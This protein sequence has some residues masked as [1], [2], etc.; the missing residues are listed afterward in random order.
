MGKYNDL[1]AHVRLLE[2]WAKSAS[3][4]EGPPTAVPV[5]ATACHDAV[6]QQ[7]ALPANI[8]R[9]VLRSA[10]AANVFGRV[11]LDE[12]LPALALT[13]SRPPTAPPP[14]PPGRPPTTAPLPGWLPD[15]LVEW[16]D[17]AADDSDP[18]DEVFPGPADAE[19]GDG[20]IGEFLSG[21][22]AAQLGALAAPSGTAAPPGLTSALPGT[23]PAPQGERCVPSPPFRLV[24]GS[25]HRR[26]GSGATAGSACVRGDAYSGGSGC[27]GGEGP[28]RRRRGGCSPASS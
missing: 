3:H 15:Q 16:A 5:A 22:G 4:A 1:V 14:P 8:L 7:S 13:T 17:L 25:P 23:A 9:R 18:N 21:L 19:A 2:G 12:A 28:R 11:S 20:V 10:D 24:G 27:A 6:A 26:G